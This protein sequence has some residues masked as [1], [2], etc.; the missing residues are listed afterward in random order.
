M[1][2]SKFPRLFFSSIF[3]AVLTLAVALPAQ[4]YFVPSTFQ[5]ATLVLGQSNFV[6]SG[7]NTSQTGLYRPEGVAVD[8]ISHKVFVADDMNNRVLRYANAA[9]LANGAAAEAVLGQPVFNSS[10]G[11][12]SQSSMQGP[13]GVTVDSAG[14]LWVA[15]TFNHRVLRFDNAASI[16]NGANANI[17]LGQSTFTDNTS[18]VAQNR[19]NAPIGIFADATGHLWVVDT[20]NS[21]VLRFNN[22]GSKTSGDNADGVLG[23]SNFTNNGSGTSQNTFAYPYGVTV[24]SAGR[25]WVADMVNNRVLRFNNAAALANGANANGVLGQPDFSTSTN[26]TSQNG[27]FEPFGVTTDPSGNLYVADT[28]NSRIMVFKTAASLANGANATY[29]IGQSDFTSNSSN[30]TATT[31]NDPFGVFYDPQQ[32]DLWVAD[33]YNHRVLLYGTPNASL[34]SDAANYGWVLESSANSNKGGSAN[35]TGTLRVGDDAA[36]KQYRS[37][38]S[39]DT[40]SLPDNAMIHKVTLKIKKAGVVGTDPLASFGGL[41]ADMQMGSFGTPALKPGDFQ[42]AAS[43]SAVGHF[44][45]ASGGWYQLVLPAAD[46]SLVNLTGPTQFRLR[47]KLDD[48]NNHS[49]NYD[50]FY[51]GNN[52]AASQPVLAVEYSL[53]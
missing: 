29:V 20:N 42:A 15:D 22:A 32:N 16:G 40:S 5:A 46:Y 38:L 44:S 41:L 7:A 25:L 24:D 39:F 23:Q 37:I 4:A 26:A 51:S 53:P 43:A 48:N 9:S 10:S 47:F 21:R 3:V 1:Q 19:M 35:A 6:S 28:Y 45:A 49:A 11:G 17:V 27:F 36:N 30:T 14:R 31:L 52:P 50:L 2:T 18:G 12:T 33:Q 34:Y 8:P 13:E